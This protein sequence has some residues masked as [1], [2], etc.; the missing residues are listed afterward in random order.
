MDVFSE[1]V[2]RREIAEKSNFGI[3]AQPSADE[4]GDFGD[5]ERRDDE[6]TWVSFEQVQA[7]GVVSVVAIDIGVERTGIDDQSDCW[8]SLARISS[9]R[10]EM[11]SRPLAPAP[12]A[13]SRRLPGWVP[14]K[15]SI[16]SR[17][18][19]DTVL[20]R[21][22]ASC[23]RRASSSSGS[24]TVVRCMYAS[25]LHH[26]GGR[27]GAHFDAQNLGTEWAMATL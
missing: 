5:D 23:R 1:Q 19:S 22:S 15:V 2:A 14:R 3:G 8:T 11:S 20:P 13:R 4:I 25:I 17:V 6:R 10:S 27:Q 9:M 18:K 26:R 24:F 7:S 12:P 16:A 21:R